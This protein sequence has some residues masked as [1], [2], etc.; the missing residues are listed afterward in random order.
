[1][2]LDL[3]AKWQF[4]LLLMSKDLQEQR[5]DEVRDHA[6]YLP[7]G[8][9]QSGRGNLRWKC[10]ASLWL[11]GSYTAVHRGRK[12]RWVTASLVFFVTVFAECYAAQRVQ[13]LS[14]SF[15]SASTWIYLQAIPRRVVAMNFFCLPPLLRS[16]EKLLLRWSDIWP[17]I[18]CV[19][20]VWRRLPL[21]SE[22]NL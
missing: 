15:P 4:E 6:F 3:R 18:F 7:F 2:D 9:W 20:S 10:P 13:F 1:M 16:G 21:A 11:R 19:F 17:K 14:I 5:D 12:A 22:F 8:S